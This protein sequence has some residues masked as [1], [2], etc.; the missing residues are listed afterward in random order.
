MRERNIQLILRVTP[1]EKDAIYKR[2]E[3]CK[4]RK[5]NTYARKMLLN[6]MIVE[7]DLSEFHELAGEVNKIGLNI[8]QI[9]KKVNATGFVNKYELESLQGAVNSIWQLLKSYLSILQSINL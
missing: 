4:F 8:N 2:M 9:V 1:E 5:F 3:L 6:G 7:V